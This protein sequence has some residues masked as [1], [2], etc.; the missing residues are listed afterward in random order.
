MILVEF[1]NKYSHFQTEMSS[2]TG[3]VILL[4]SVHCFVCTC[5]SSDDVISRQKRADDLGQTEAVMTQLTQKVDALTA[6][7]TQQN[8]QMT[9]MQAE[10]TSL[11]NR[12]SE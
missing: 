2:F 10:L 6:Q 4:I 1:H 7:L 5:A 8:A 12:D 11:K 9:Q 3:I